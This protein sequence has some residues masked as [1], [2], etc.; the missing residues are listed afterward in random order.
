MKAKQRWRYAN[1][2]ASCPCEEDAKRAVVSPEAMWACSYEHWTEWQV[3]HLI[4]AS[5]ILDGM[6]CEEL[7]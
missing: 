1:R 3:G 5:L 2:V 7:P 4:A 6:S